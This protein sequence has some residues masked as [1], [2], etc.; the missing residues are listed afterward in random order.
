MKIKIHG[1]SPCTIA[2]IHGGPG[3]A[4]EMAPVAR[5]LAA[6]GRGVLEPIQSATSLQGQITE[7]KTALESAATLPVTLIGFSWGAWLSYLV[8]AHHPPLVEK[9]ILVGSGPFEERYVE[10]LKETRQ[11]RLS[12]EERKEFSTI[13]TG[14][15][16]PKA[17]KKD[18]LL[19]RLGSLAAKT[20]TYDPLPKDDE[21]S[22]TI[23]LQGDLFQQ[24]WEEAAQLRKS[25]RLLEFGK[26]IT[27]PVVAVHGDYDPHPAEGVRVP[28]S[29]VLR[30]LRFIL[31]PNCGHK[32]WVERQAKGRFYEVLEK[33]L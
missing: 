4:G 15:G 7:L 12:V 31:L 9:L 23:M 21:E 10:K 13:I 17:E 11:S 29:A 5:E 2:V 24:V 25:G 1:Q 20:D 30:D 6:A 18:A 14:L 33:E 19:S 8:A 32:P 28:L 3:A 16:N 27:C 26:T 22:K